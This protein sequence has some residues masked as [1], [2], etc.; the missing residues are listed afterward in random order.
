MPRSVWLIFLLVFAAV[1]AGAQSASDD[2]KLVADIRRDL[3][4]I[5]AAMADIN[6]E[7]SR[8]RAHI[9][10]REKALVA[11]KN[12]EERLRKINSENIAR[13]NQAAIQ[14]MRMEQ[15]PLQA[16]LAYDVMT[17]RPGR[18]AVLK[19]TNNAALKQVEE[20][21]TQ[22][23]SLIA[24]SGR[25][26]AQQRT[27]GDVAAQLETQQQRLTSVR[28]QQAKLLSLSSHEREAL[29]KK[30]KEL[31]GNGSLDSLLTL[32]HRLSDLMPRLNTLAEAPL[33]VQGRIITAWGD[34]HPQTSIRS[35]GVTL[36]ANAAEKVI[37]V[38][39]GHVIYSGPFKGYGNL[40]ILEHGRGTHTLY[41]GLAEENLGR[42]GD[43][44]PAGEPLGLMPATDEAHLYMEVRVNGNLRDPLRWLSAQK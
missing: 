42:V 35:N 24:L 43:F 10:D 14:L 26:E 20:S 3:Q 31:G 44:I 6:T 39:G 21:Q 40:V 5:D 4:R 30:A 13:F 9:A 36:A 25:M 34:L 27:V 29:I 33:P 22:L 8:M 17:I 23:A 12:E 41:S 38:Q 28:Q 18:E 19:V 11:L 32:R 7:I 2:A 37:A 16:L 1:P 15:R